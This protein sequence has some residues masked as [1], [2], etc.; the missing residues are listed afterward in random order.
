MRETEHLVPLPGGG[1]IVLYHLDPPESPRAAVIVTHGTIS[2]ADSVRDLARYLVDLGFD[3]WLLEWGGHGKS[4]AASRRQDFEYA[5]LHDVPAAVGAVLEATGRDR[6]F[7]V[8]HSGGGLL[9]LMYLARHSEARERIAGLVTMGAQVTDAAIGAAGMLKTVLLWSVTTVLGRTPKLL[10]PMGS[11]GE[12]TRL[13]A[14]WSVWNLRRR[15]LGGDGLDYVEAIASL[16]VPALVF[17]GVRDTIAPHSGCRRLFDALGSRDKT[18]VLGS[19]S[20]GFA[21]NLSHGGLVLGQ[22]AREEVFP[23]IGEWLTRR[24]PRPTMVGS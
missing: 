15:W 12:P 4:R 24:A 8:S 1:R 3:V 20:E 7:W 10:V 11:E 5:A 16:M 13:L 19:T 14:Q 9:A 22:V 23:R 6:L 18:W 21:K 2:N 17:A